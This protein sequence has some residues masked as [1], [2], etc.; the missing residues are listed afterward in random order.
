MATFEARAKVALSNALRRALSDGVSAHFVGGTHTRR[1]AD[2]LLPSLSQQQVATLREQLEAGAGGELRPSKSGKRPAHAPY[3][4]A[5][6]A[7]NAFG[8][9]LGRESELR[10][11][12]LGGFNAQLEIESRQHIKHGGGTAN[13]DVLLRNDAVV[14]GVESKLTEPLRPHSPVRWRTPYHQPEMKTILTGGWSQVF[15]KS[16]AGTWQPQYLGIEQLIKHALA[17]CSRFPEPELHLVYVWW[18]PENPEELPE[19]ATHREE[20]ADLQDRLRDSSPILHAVT[21]RQLF[22]EWTALG[23]SDVDRYLAQLA[24]RYVLEV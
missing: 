12:G 7:I 18:E 1:F 17:L 20:L 9:W 2:N 10:V 15:A 11:A 24:E 14:V 3:S 23:S 6:L 4:S 5:A 22:A 19:L 13:L 8:S 16:L 21:Y